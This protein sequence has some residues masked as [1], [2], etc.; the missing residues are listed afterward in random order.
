MRSYRRRVVSVQTI[1]VSFESSNNPSE[2]QVTDIIQLVS[3]WTL[4]RTLVFEASKM[5]WELDDIPTSKT[6]LHMHGVI[7]VGRN[8]MNTPEL[9]KR[10]EAIFTGR[11]DNSKR[12]TRYFNYFRAIKV[13]ACDVMKRNKSSK[14]TIVGHAMGTLGYAS[15][16]TAKTKRVLNLNN[17][18]IPNWFFNSAMMDYFP[19]EKSQNQAF[20]SSIVSSSKGVAGQA[21]ALFLAMQKKGYVHTADGYNTLEIRK[22][23]D[24]LSGLSTEEFSSIKRLKL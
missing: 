24:G 14:H 20:F 19:T 1:V 8:P 12:D 9:K 13:E 3:G 7:S 22:I 5:N 23:I 15:K 2:S 11:S 16:D 4:S 6:D 17:N 21:K 18:D 10:L